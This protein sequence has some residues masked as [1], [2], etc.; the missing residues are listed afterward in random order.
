MEGPPCILTRSGSFDR[1]SSFSIEY[2]L[3]VQ[4]VVKAVTALHEVSS[5]NGIGSEVTTFHVPTDR[6]GAR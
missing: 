6:C 1:L 5:C 2:F 3:G 4:E